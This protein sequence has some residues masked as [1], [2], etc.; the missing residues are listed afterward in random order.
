MVPMG[1]RIS[2]ETHPRRKRKGVSF[3]HSPLKFRDLVRRSIERIGAART[4]RKLEYVGRSAKIGSKGSQMNSVEDD[5]FSLLDTVTQLPNTEWEQTL[6]LGP[7]GPRSQRLIELTGLSTE[8]LNNALTWLVQ[9]DAIEVIE[10]QHQSKKF[11]YTRLQRLT[12]AG[13]LLHAQI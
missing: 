5:A 3:T 11:Y 1:Q 13:A 6:G 12:P 2:E 7:L 10:R 8:E 4:V 9:R